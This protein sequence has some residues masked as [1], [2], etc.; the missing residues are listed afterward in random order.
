LAD[1][2]VEQLHWNQ[3]RKQFLLD[4]KAS[5]FNHITK[6]Q[7]G[8][9]STDYWT[10]Y[11]SAWARIGDF[12]ASKVFKDIDNGRK[13]IRTHA[14]RTTIHVMHTDNLSLILSATGP[15]LYRAYRNDKYRKM[16]ILSDSEIED[17]LGQVRS[18][19][20]DGP[21]QTSELKKIVPKVGENVRSA[22]LM[23]MARGEVVRAKAKH[24]RSN[25]TSYALLENWVKGFKLEIMDEEEAISQLIRQHIELFG[26]VSVEDTAWWFKQTK[27]TVK[28]TIKEL[29]DDVVDLKVDGKEKFVSVMDLD[30]ATSLEPP[31]QRPVWFLPYEDHFLKAFID[32]RRFISEEIQPKTSPAD[33]KHFW[34]SKPDEPRVMPS[35]GIRATGEVRPTIWLDG[36][37]VGRWEIDDAG[38]QKKI[39]IS[40]YPKVAKKHLERIEEVRS[41]LE[42]FINTSLLPI[43]GEN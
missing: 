5:D 18:A 4:E 25:L 9:H 10:P 39:V 30:V 23:L 1:V 3:L 16:D 41:N 13:I 21:L 19:L 20:E 31:N 2:S 29:S 42:N 38:K 27:T 17:M 7:L 14:F 22:L 12:D 28:N 24:A 35:P 26:P 11:L 33:K 8:L 40:I 43:S 6:A 34:P 36:K 37:V 15:S 32:R